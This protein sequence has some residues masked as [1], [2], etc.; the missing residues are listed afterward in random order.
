MKKF[1]LLTLF[2]LISINY[3][4]WIQTDGPTGG[5]VKALIC[6]GSLTFA[7]TNGQG[8]FISSNNGQSWVQ[9][10]QNDPVLCSSLVRCFALQDNYI[11]AGT[12]N[13]G[14]YSSTD[15]GQTWNLVIFLFLSINCLAIDGENIYA[16]TS[17]GI[18]L[19]TN[20][21]QTF[22]QLALESQSVQAIAIK[23][24][25]I[26]AGTNQKLFISSDNGQTWNQQNY[27][28]Y[29]IT[30]KNNNVFIGTSL[31]VRKSTDN[32][33]TW[34][35]SLD[36]R[37][38]SLTTYGGYIYAGLS[39][40]YISSDNGQNWFR[41]PLPNNHPNIAAAFAIN[42]SKN[43]FAG[44]NGIFVSSNNGQSWTETP[45]YNH[46]IFSLLTIGQN[47]F[48]GTLYGLYSTSDEGSMW[49]TTSLNS[50]LPINCL[51]G[52]GTNIFAAFGQGIF[53]STNS[54]LTWTQ[55]GFYD[56]AVS[57]LC[58]NGQTIFAGTSFGL[59]IST[60]YGQT[61]LTSILNDY[62]KY[63]ANNGSNIFAGTTDKIYYSPDNGQ[64][65]T[66]T[67]IDSTYSIHSLGVN[68]STVFTG[69]GNGLYISTNNGQLWTQSMGESSVNS[70]ISFDSIVFVGSSQGVY[71]SRDN[72]ATWTKINEGLEYKPVL[73][74]AIA[75]DY[76][77]AGTR[78]Y[79][80]WKRYIPELSGIENINN[81]VPRNYKLYQNYPNP[82]NPTTKIKYDI[83]KE[84]FITIKIY[85]IVGREI[86]S[87][88][89][90][91]L[92]GKYEMTFDGSKYASGIYFYRIQAGDF[93]AVK[94]MLMIK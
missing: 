24:S 26:F 80:V 19:S 86:Y 47:I 36:K 3:S 87:T 82:F 20:H 10:A 41:S 91:N 66:L 64:S 1:I 31:E 69:T 14:L 33:T 39:S 46:Y 11:Y 32:G 94:K 13:N 35:L 43:I 81:S 52:M 85:D 88:H 37:P 12:W 55:S 92:P 75:N 40:I 74:L 9:A 29:C 57:A 45:F 71:F 18:F 49:D 62:I 6:S 15:N 73:S 89:E 72:G 28:V 63:L 17:N 79:S 21:G 93:V 90:Y 25:Y 56:T 38:Y 42:Y 48:A 50:G 2:F 27:G 16:G 34:K 76:I 67:T 4:Q 78:G 68:G 53:R 77:Y 44:G 60:N 61:W 30:I 5:N 84:G 22:N 23:G 51:A 58:V 65:W 59:Y 70:I 83:P 8:I 7:G 54:G